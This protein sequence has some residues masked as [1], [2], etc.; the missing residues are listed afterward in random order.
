VPDV[1]RVELPDI[2][3]ATSLTQELFGRFHVELV[4]REGAWEVEVPQRP[5]AASSTPQLLTAVEQW[6]NLYGLD[7]VT[8][9][10]NGRERTLQRHPEH[11][12]AS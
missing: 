10:M 5:A 6:L 2:E 4:T 9:H 12:S 1:I 11:G 7:H 8:V 3:S